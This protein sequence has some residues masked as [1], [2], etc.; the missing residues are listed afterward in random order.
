MEELSSIYSRA[1]PMKPADD[2]FFAD[3]DRIE[4]KF[5]VTG[6][7]TIAKKE[8]HEACVRGRKR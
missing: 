4:A 7:M 2:E 8:F 5:A 1:F 6:N 3:L